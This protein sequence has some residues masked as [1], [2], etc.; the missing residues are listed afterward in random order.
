MGL[1]ETYDRIAEDWHTD[2]AHDTWWKDG[3]DHLITMLPSHGT[4]LD[5]GCG[6]GEKAKYLIE[7]GFSVVGIDISD[8]FLAIARRIAPA[9]DFRK[10][11]M[12]ELDSIPEQFDAV[13]ASASLLHIPRA[14][15]PAVIADMAAR[16]KPGGYLY[17]TVKEAREGEPDESVAKE[18]D[19]GYDYERFFSYFRMSE[20]AS[21][22]SA[23]GL[24]VVWEL[25]DS[26]HK[27]VWLKILGKK[28]S[29]E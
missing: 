29:H 25:R 6:S 28:P 26:T 22:L 27:T 18:N 7:H 24:K 3:V 21:F 12:T 17:L 14:D 13:F 4:V 2:H 10:M 1:K 23:A 5:V 8:G 19:Y 16:T 20:L 15:A 11:S 9:A